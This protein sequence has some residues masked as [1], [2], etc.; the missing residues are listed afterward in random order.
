[1][2]QSIAP[3]I[4]SVKGQALLA[5]LFSRSLTAVPAWAD[6][7]DNHRLKMAAPRSEA[8]ADPG[9]LARQCR[10]RPGAIVLLEPGTVVLDLDRKHGNDAVTWFERRWG[11]LADTTPVVTPSGGWHLWFDVPRDL[12][13][14]VRSSALAPGVDVLGTRGNVPL[15]GSASKR[16]A[17]SLPDNFTIAPMPEA[18]ADAIASTPPSAP[19]KVVAEARKTTRYGQAT[20][21]ALAAE[22]RSE[23]NYPSQ[24]LNRAAFQAGQRAAEIAFDDVSIIVD[25][26]VVAGVPSREAERTVERAFRAGQRFP[27]T[28]GGVR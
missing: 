3:F 6:P 24:A 14:P 13:F 8:T 17:Y 16:G 11:R 5:V 18:L 15:P 19:S 20:L 28:R 25:A 4:R 12:Y 9:A 10:D 2:S 7:A 22:V 26:A 27:K 21:M 23:R 1:M